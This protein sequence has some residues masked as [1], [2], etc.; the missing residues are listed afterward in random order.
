MT[1]QRK[2]SASWPLSRYVSQ[3]AGSL[4]GS[5]VTLSESKRTRHGTGK[6]ATRKHSDPIQEPSSGRGRREGRTGHVASIGGRRLSRAKQGQRVCPP[7]LRGKGAR[8][9]LSSRTCRAPPPRSC[10]TGC[11]RSLPAGRRWWSS[12]QPVAARR[13]RVRDAG[14]IAR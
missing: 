6:R 10:Y 8:R 5:A 1:L 3:F 7:T 2:T 13:C 4:V 14:C 11:Y 9:A 12:P